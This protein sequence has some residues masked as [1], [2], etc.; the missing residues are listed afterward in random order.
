MMALALNSGGL[1]NVVLLR[2]V[3]I[4]VGVLVLVLIG[5]AALM[6]LKRQG[7]IDKRAVSRASEKLGPIART[8]IENRRGGERDEQRGRRAGLLNTVL[9]VLNDRDRRR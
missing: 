4:A 2:F 6:M 8:L 5:F 9:A 1:M 3:L 7:S